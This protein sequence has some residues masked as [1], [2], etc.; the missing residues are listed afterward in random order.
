MISQ[1]QRAAQYVSITRDRGIGWKILRS[2]ENVLG[3]FWQGKVIGEKQ[4]ESILGK[5]DHFVRYG[6][7]TAYC[8]SEICTEVGFANELAP[9]R[10]VS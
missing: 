7:N 2:T 3:F 9:A 5:Q 4:I 1:L 6:H 10:L 8:V